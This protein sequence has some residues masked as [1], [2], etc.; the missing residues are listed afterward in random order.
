MLWSTLLLVAFVCLRL[1][2]DFKNMSALVKIIY[3][4]AIPLGI[5][6]A[7]ENDMFARIFGVIFVVSCITLIIQTFYEFKQI[8]NE[9]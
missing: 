3:I 8:N 4:L 9:E 1:L 6:I 7:F 5:S 2:Y